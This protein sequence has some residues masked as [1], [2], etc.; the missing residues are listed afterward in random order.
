MLHGKRAFERILWSFRNVLVDSLAWLF[1]DLNDPRLSSPNPL[2]K[3][4]L[5]IRRCEPRVDHARKVKVPLFG[6]EFSR[7]EDGEED[8]MEILEWVSLALAGSPRIEVDDRIDSYLCRYQI[9]GSLDLN[10]PPEEQSLVKLHWHGLLPSSLSTKIFLLALQTT[11][12]KW[13]A[14]S[15]TS[16]DD[17]TITVLKTD[18]VSLT[19]SY[20]D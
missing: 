12:D 16:F 18:D 19:W 13:F 15:A 17:S 10:A 1:V 20:E 5:Q 14:M 4:A 6:R 2:T 11:G 3:F 9:P 7:D 8:A